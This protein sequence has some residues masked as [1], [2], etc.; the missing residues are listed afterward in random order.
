[1]IRKLISGGQTGVDQGALDF[2][3]DNGI[4][5]GGFCPKGRKCETGKIPDRYP[6]IELEGYNYK[7]RT[8]KN[9]QESDGTLILLKE[10]KIDRGTS[11]TLTLCYVFNKPFLLL[12][13]DYD[14]NLLK[15]NCK[16]WLGL[17][18]INVLN[19]AGS[20]ESQA[21][22]IQKETR[23]LLPFIMSEEDKLGV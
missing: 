9:I 5:C 6:L 7:T 19:V 17:H 11:L 3:L 22:G 8:R 14:Y 10:G 21:P 12:D 20:R 1:M 2:A 13:M 16:K 18:Q 15:S 4:E 23:E